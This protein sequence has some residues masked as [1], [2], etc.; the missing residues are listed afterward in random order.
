MGM[1]DISHCNTGPY[2]DFRH[3]GQSATGQAPC[4][5]R[6]VGVGSFPLTKCNHP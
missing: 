5:C 6:D 1:S 2:M 4:G 3:L